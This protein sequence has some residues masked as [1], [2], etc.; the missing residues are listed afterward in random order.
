V[1]VSIKSA[2]E[3]ELMRVA[4]RIVANTLVELRAAVEPGITTKEL[5]RI[6]ERTIKAQGGDPAF[7]Y[8][9]HF[10]GSVCVSVN[11]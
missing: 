4:S 7:P 5:D 2:R 8:V 6:A 9:N 10:P 1:S 11:N 3:V